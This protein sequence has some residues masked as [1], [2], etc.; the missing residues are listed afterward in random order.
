ML[1]DREF[2]GFITKEHFQEG[3]NAI[4]NANSRPTYTDSTPTGNEWTYNSTLQCMHMKNIDTT[5][6]GYC[7]Q[8]FGELRVGDII[9]VVAEV[10]SIS[11]VK[12]KIAIDARLDAQYWTNKATIQ[13]DKTEEWEVI[14]LKYVVQ[15]NKID[16]RATIGIWSADIGEFYVR[17]I[18]IEVL[19]QERKKRTITR[20]AM[21]RKVDDTWEVRTDFANDECTVTVYDYRTLQITFAKPIPTSLR[22]S[23]FVSN[24]YYTILNQYIVR[25]S[26]SY[27]DNLL[28]RF[29]SLENLENAVPLEDI[30]NNTHFAVL[31]IGS[32]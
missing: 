7:V 2:Y 31:L 23:C 20:V 13:A 8:E 11:G 30:P 25:G 24:E 32:V 3:I 15:D 29:F 16:H 1:F 28:V 12:P 26:F 9:E 10:Y 4:P 5:K 22:A 17:N 6:V 18:R 21:I 27:N 14:K 19:T